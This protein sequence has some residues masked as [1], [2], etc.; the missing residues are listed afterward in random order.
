LL[1]HYGKTVRKQYDSLFPKFFASLSKKDEKKKKQKSPK[2][3]YKVGAFF[4][5][6]PP[7]AERSGT[8]Q[9]VGSPSSFRVSVLV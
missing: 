1:Q 3:S 9:A 8:D 5:P 6:F 2:E 4:H 7:A